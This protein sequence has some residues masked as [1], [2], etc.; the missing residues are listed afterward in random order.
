MFGTSTGSGFAD[1]PPYDEDHNGGVSTGDELRTL[2][3]L[4]IA[5]IGLEAKSLDGQTAG[6]ATVRAVGR[7]TRTDG[8][9]GNVYEAIFPTDQTD[10]IWRGESGQPP[11]AP[12]RPS[13]LQRVSPA[14]RRTLKPWKTL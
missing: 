7:C 9:S 10:T 8:T 4:D 2:G 5:V 11:W 1:L 3:A 6:G 12:A 13:R 14:R